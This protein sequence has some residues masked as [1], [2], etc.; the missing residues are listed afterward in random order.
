MIMVALLASSSVWPSARRA[1][2]TQRAAAGH[3]A[4]LAFELHRLAGAGANRR[5]RRARHHVGNGRRHMLRDQL[6][7]TGDARRSADIA[8]AADRIRHHDLDRLG[9]I[10][11]RLHATRE[12]Q[13]PREQNEGAMS[14]G[15]HAATYGCSLSFR[16]P[17]LPIARLGQSG[18]TLF[19]IRVTSTRLDDGDLHELPVVSLQTRIAESQDSAPLRREALVARVAS[20]GSASA[21]VERVQFV[22]IA[23][24]LPWRKARPAKNGSPH[25]E[26][27]IVGS[28]GISADRAWR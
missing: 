10:R 16:S 11:L 14:H 2:D 8:R 22:T 4:R 27:S 6:V 3:A 24:G 1:R 28:S 5:S 18:V 19:T 21:F 7:G 15:G 17:A 9:R 20:T 12:R 26:S 23:S 13:Q 25:T